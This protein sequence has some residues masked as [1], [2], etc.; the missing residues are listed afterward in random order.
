MP[1]DAL[2]RDRFEAG[3][4]SSHDLF[5]LLASVNQEA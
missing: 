1:L 2:E 5:N 4:G 3:Q